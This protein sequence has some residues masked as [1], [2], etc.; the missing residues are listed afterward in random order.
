MFDLALIQIRNKFQSETFTRAATALKYIISLSSSCKNIEIELVQEVEDFRKFQEIGLE[1]KRF[2]NKLK[3]F[4]FSSEFL[5]TSRFSEKIQFFRPIFRDFRTNIF[6][7]EEI[8]QAY[9]TESITY[10]FHLFQII[11]EFAILLRLFRA[12]LMNLLEP[13]RHILLVLFSTLVKLDARLVVSYP[14]LAKVAKLTTLRF[15]IIRPENE[16]KNES[17]LI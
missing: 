15:P 14:T 17:L 6:N 7:R 4:T 11:L 2:L 16:K 5:K 8:T 1:N 13:L 9:N 10:R 3:T 12:V